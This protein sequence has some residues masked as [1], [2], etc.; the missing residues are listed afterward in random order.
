[1]FL[2]SRFYTTI[3]ALVLRSP[4]MQPLFKKEVEFDLILS[5]MTNMEAFIGF[6]ELFNASFIAVSTSVT[7]KCINDLVGTPQPASYIP[8]NFL[9]FTD[10]MT[11]KE[12]AGNFLIGILEDV[13]DL[14]AHK[15]NQ[16]SRD[17]QWKYS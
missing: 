7:N 8:N 2:Q 10:N 16:V 6:A 4:T 11:L 13:I 1:M 3:T 17:F 14:V 12:R 5:E 9:G 15:P